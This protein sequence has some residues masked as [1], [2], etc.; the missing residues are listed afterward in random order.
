MIDEFH[1]MFMYR[2]IQAEAATTDLKTLNQLLKKFRKVVAE[3]RE[4]YLEI[5]EKKAQK[6]RA[7]RLQLLLEKMGRDRVSPE[8]LYH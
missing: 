2:K 7:K 3:R 8:D 5:G 6:L 1:V 4:E